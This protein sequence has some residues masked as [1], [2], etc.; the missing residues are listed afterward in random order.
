M[1]NPNLTRRVVFLVALA[2]AGFACGTQADTVSDNLGSSLGGARAGWGVPPIQTLK[3]TETYLAVLNIIRSEYAPQKEGAKT[4]DAVA[5][6]YA[7]IDGMLATLHDRYTEF[8][9]PKEYASN[10]EETSGV[11]AG[12][13]ATLD[14][15]GDKKVVV[16]DTITDSPAAKMGILPGDI[17]TQ[18][19]GVAV[20]GKTLD[21][22]IERIKG[23]PGSTVRITIARANHPAP[24]QVLLTRALVATP[25][26]ESRMED[27]PSHIGYIS[28]SMFGETA[29]TQFASALAKLE[30]RKMR[31]LIFDL[32]DNPGGLLTVAQDLASRFVAEGTVVWIQEKSGKMSPLSVERGKHQ[33]GL[34]SG[35][36]PVVVLVNGNSAS[37]AEIVAGAIKDH[38]VGTL[39]G[40]RTFGKGLV[41]TIF[42]L[43]DDSAVKVTTQHYFTPNKTDINKKYD[44]LT[45]ARISGGIIPDVTMELTDSDWEHMREARRSNPRD[46]LAPDRLDPQMQTALEILRKQLEAR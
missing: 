18:V 22:T 6:T 14:I 27:E 24:M 45:G 2:V 8:W 25:L 32:R 11:F 16:M 46:R 19:D 33:G 38:E 37:A 43:D 34:S 29:D 5:L 17:V 20:S 4:P 44:P 40:T 31:G 36:Y 13:G 41:Q 42:P 9:T 23:D 12:I 35:K 28:L 26:V 15:S 21:A 7:A 10:M 1:R 30:G 3:P 39:V